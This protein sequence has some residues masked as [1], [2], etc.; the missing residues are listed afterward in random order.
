MASKA[1]FQDLLLKKGEK[2]ALLGALVLFGLFRS[3]NSI[4]PTE[5][6]L[7]TKSS[8]PRNSATTTSSA[9]K[10][11]RAS[12]ATPLRPSDRARSLRPGDSQTVTSAISTSRVGE[13]HCESADFLR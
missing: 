8:G 3:I 1:G 7:V 5:V 2:F 4:R 9:S 13:I 12:G 11:K 10:V 6:G